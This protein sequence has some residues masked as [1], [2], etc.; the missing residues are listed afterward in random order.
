MED[1]LDQELIDLLEEDET[2]KTK[3]EKPKTVENPIIE[4]DT[5]AIPEPIIEQVSVKIEKE[6]IPEK[7]QI[8]TLVPEPT[9]TPVTIKTLEN[10]EQ[11]ITKTEQEEK[12][13]ASKEFL[14]KFVNVANEIV[15]N[16]TKDRNQIEEAIKYFSEEV[17]E[18]RQL[19]IKLPP[20]L[21]DGWVKL[22]A[23]KSDVNANATG[24]LD[25][26]AKLLAAAKNNNLIININDNNPGI[27]LEEILSQPAKEDE[28]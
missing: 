19:G 11:Q 17:K 23:T 26:M 7:I 10:I 1:E 12:T 3:Q 28:E 25:S 13:F 2:K 9:I 6:S 22:L 20:A 16:H 5:A 14:E 18:A 8:Q 27:N 21:I 24:V 15:E 4:S